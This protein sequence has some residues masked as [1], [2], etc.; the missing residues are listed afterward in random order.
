MRKLKLRQK[1]REQREREQLENMD[2]EER[3]YPEHLKPIQQ[4]VDKLE[5][6]AMNIIF[7]LFPKKI[8]LLDQTLE[9]GQSFRL[10]GRD[11]LPSPIPHIP[12]QR[13]DGQPD[14]TIP[15]PSNDAVVKQ[16]EALKLEVLEQAEC[17]NTLTIWIEL[18]VP[19]IEDGN[20]FG[21]EIQQEIL[22]QLQSSMT[23]S[24]A[25]LDSST[26]Y[27]LA[28][29][30][31]VSKALKYPGVVDFRRTITELDEKQYIKAH[32]FML[33]LRNDYALLF[34]II[35]KNIDRLASP[36]DQ[37]DATSHLYH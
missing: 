21:V 1:E 36:R 2:T 5:E 22:S 3:E 33:D 32:L 6:K 24:L 26:E 30:G 17:L 16:L 23:S 7:T 31:I 25:A 9:S 20:N 34:D 12:S 19:R 13:T 35:S 14:Y 15:V 28:R 18:N 27:F 29:A 8:E 37:S 4:L 10:P 11:A